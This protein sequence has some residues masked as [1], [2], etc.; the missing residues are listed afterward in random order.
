MKKLEMLFPSSKESEDFR[1]FKKLSIAKASELVTANSEEKDTE[2]EKDR[3]LFT[4]MKTPN[5]LKLL[6]V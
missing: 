5:W 4:S 1:M 2:L 3:L 6:E